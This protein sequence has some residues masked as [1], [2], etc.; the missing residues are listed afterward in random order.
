VAKLKLS[1]AVSLATIVYGYSSVLSD[2]M[3]NSFPTAETIRYLLRYKWLLMGI[4]VVVALGT[5]I[6]TRTL[7]NY[8]KSTINCVPATSDQGLLGGAAG[9]LGSALKDFGLSKLSGGGGEQY[10]FVLI[11]FT[12]QI[13][14]SMIARFDLRREYELEDKPMKDVRKEFEDNLDV[15]LHAEGNYEISIWS[16]DSVKAA[17]MCQTYV[18]YANG[19]ANNIHRQDAAKT[20]GYL[21]GRLGLID[22]TLDALTDSLQYYSRTY[23]MFS[24]EDQAKASATAIAEAK[25]NVLQQETILGL[26]ETSYGPNDA[27]VRAQKT[28][29]QDLKQRTESMLRTPGLA[30]DFAITDAAG[31]GAR[32]M[33]ILGDFEAHA[34]LKA[35]L[36]PSFEQ[37]QLDQMKSTP[38]LLVVDSPIPAEKKDRPK[39]ALIS[40]G[41]GLGMG[42]LTMIVLLAIRA[43]R[44]MMNAES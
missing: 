31:I 19:I 5:H 24:P 32:Y 11:F 42:I 3:S 40:A 23:L 30:G 28:L 44:T 29:V 26:L 43:Y 20:Y 37:A 22:S 38:S 6:Y 13:Q 35:F 18:D 16:R 10:E 33:R 9:G 8:Y 2:D 27:Q 21:K 1:G 25:A 4:T 39:R 36:M 7:P 15:E 17:T 34:K 41:A 14:D 12:R